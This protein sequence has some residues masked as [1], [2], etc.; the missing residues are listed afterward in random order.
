MDLSILIHPFEIAFLDPSILTRLLRSIFFYPSIWTCL[1]ELIYFDMY[2]WTCHLKKK[3]LVRSGLV[4]ESFGEI[5]GQ[6]KYGE[7]LCAKKQTTEHLNMDPSRFLLFCL[8]DL[9]GIWSLTTSRVLER[10]R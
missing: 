6:G 4:P 1:F 9:G 8:G 2:S 10:S 7:S 3:V 5:R